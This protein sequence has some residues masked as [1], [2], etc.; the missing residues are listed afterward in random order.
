MASSRA[1]ASNT[2]TLFLSGDVM[3]GRGIDQILRHPGDPELHEDYLKSALDYVALAERAHGPIPRAAADAY[4]W[5]DALTALDRIA[6]DLRLINLETAATACSDW[7][8]KGIN[9]RM[10]P[11][12]A[13]ILTAAEIDACSLANNHVLDW[14]PAGLFE[15]LATL[16]RIGVV[17]VGAGQSRD[18]AATPGVFEVPGG[19]VIVFAYGVPSSGVPRHWAAGTHRPGV[20]ILRD[21]SMA[22]VDG[23]AAQV[24]A[25]KRSGDIVVLSLHWGSNWG[26]EI[27][28]EER[29]F[30]HALVDRAGIDLV[31]GHSS[32]HPKAV[33]VYR[34]RPI[35]YGCGDFINDYEGIAGHESYRGDLVLMYCATLA[36]TGG[37]LK[38]LE[39]VPFKMCNF[40]LQRTSG[41]DTDW[42]R[43]RLDRESQAFGTG[44]VRN[45]DGRLILRWPVDASEPAS[46]AS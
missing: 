3:T 45:Q 10:H 17:P 19:R 20:N 27:A 22:S 35:L 9:Y 24:A 11:D 15:T 42:L 1:S 34:N 33:E 41:S 31:W 38:R 14:G 5:G 25:V 7:E 46:G 23:V 12:N 29:I 4:V 40:R 28:A 30:A 32:H 2:V 26:Y 36:V 13:G 43:T 6:P 16:R 37:S 18:E 21:L 39:M 8:P 44:V